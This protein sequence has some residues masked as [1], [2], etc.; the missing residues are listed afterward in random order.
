MSLILICYVVP[1]FMK[2]LTLS[3]TSFL[4]CQ[5]TLDRSS[6]SG[7]AYE[8][9]GIGGKA[10]IMSKVHLSDIIST[11]RFPLALLRRWSHEWIEYLSV[12]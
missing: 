12:E 6:V 8:V 9:R 5:T 2:S 1:K 7:Y 4:V 3:L 11:N 10:Y